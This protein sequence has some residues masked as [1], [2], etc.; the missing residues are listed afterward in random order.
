[1]HPRKTRIRSSLSDGSSEPERRLD[2]VLLA[3]GSE[4]VKIAGGEFWWSG[5]DEREREGKKEEKR[6]WERSVSKSK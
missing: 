1:M 5:R 3:L 4:S 6:V 2:L